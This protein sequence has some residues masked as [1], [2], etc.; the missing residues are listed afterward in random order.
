MKHPGRET[1]A[2]IKE[3]LAIS[4]MVVTARTDGS[5]GFQ[6]TIKATVNVDKFRYHLL[7]WIVNKQIP[8]DKVK[9]ED[10]REI[11]LSLSVTID[12]YLI[13]SSQTI[14]N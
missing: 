5:L 3:A 12:R 9:D 11:L 10:F 2:D 1:R 13:Q 6:L 4:D 8:F 7:R 14:R